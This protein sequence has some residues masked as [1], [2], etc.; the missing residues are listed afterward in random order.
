MIDNNSQNKN[1]TD[2][3]R[4]M[5]AELEHE[6][7]FEIGDLIAERYRVNAPIGF[8]GFAEVYRCQ[9]T[10]LKR[11]VAIKV[12]TNENATL[13]DEALTAAQLN[14]PNIVQVYDIASIQKEGTP[15]I[16]LEY[17]EGETLEKKINLA[18]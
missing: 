15:I 11:E 2:S 14:H 7:R 9:D 5:Q 6:Y 17:I 10:Q 8:G 3:Q 18:K 12:L 13:E 1:P 4:R 16:V